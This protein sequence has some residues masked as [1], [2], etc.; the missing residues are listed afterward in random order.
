MTCCC[1]EWPWGVCAEGCSA[2]SGGWPSAKPGYGGRS[3]RVP[4]AD[5]LTVTSEAM[6]GGDGMALSFLSLGGAGNQGVKG[7]GQWRGRNMV[8]SR[9]LCTRLKGALALALSFCDSGT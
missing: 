1:V 8:G 3:L 9:S 6:W 4:V 5:R 2:W 7:V